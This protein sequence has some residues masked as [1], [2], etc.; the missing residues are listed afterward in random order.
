[1]SKSNKNSNKL[2]NFFKQVNQ[3][4]FH[5]SKDIR[6][7]RLL[8]NNLYDELNILKKKQNFTING[9][10]INTNL[11]AKLEAEKEILISVL[12]ILQE[13]SLEYISQLTELNYH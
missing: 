3:I 4:N 1:M 6:K 10:F 13:K 7:M 12:F 9:T 5:D 11:Y 2:S 8:L